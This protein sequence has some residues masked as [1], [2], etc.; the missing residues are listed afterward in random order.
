M[1]FQIPTLILSFRSRSGV[2]HRRRRAGLDAVAIQSS[3]FPFVMGLALSN[4]IAGI[5]ERVPKFS[6][7]SAS[8]G[9]D[10]AHAVLLVQSF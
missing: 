3:F 10:R 9:R 2:L 5:G 7:V 6:C 8:C 4:P 1:P